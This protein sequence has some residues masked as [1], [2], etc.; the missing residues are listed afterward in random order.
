MTKRS[1]KNNIIKVI[2]TLLLCVYSTTILPIQLNYIKE[3]LNIKSE[4]GFMIKEVEAM[5]SNML[6]E[7]EVYDLI[8]NSGVKII[9]CTAINNFS[10]ESEY[11]V[12]NSTQGDL[13]GSNTLTF[14]I[15]DDGN[16]LTYLASYSI[17]YDSI[18]FNNNNEITL[19]VICS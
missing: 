8:K 19:R 13:E 15:A 7:K 1:V 12:Y 10:E 9:G 5:A 16:L 4:I 18:E 3:G 17:V 2:V 11:T 14:I 6:T